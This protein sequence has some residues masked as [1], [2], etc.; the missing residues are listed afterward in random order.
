MQDYFSTEQGSERC[1]LR[2]TVLNYD[3]KSFP[4]TV[5]PSLFFPPREYRLPSLGSGKNA[6]LVEQTEEINSELLI[7]YVRQQFE[8]QWDKQDVYGFIVCRYNIT[9]CMCIT[10]TNWYILCYVRGNLKNW[11]CEKSKEDKMLVRTDKNPIKQWREKWPVAAES[12]KRWA[13]LT[14]SC[15]GLK[16]QMNVSFP[17]ANTRQIYLLVVFCE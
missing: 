12:E 15:Q 10:K 7:N 4:L 8:G 9:I 16:V 14:F 2:V 11:I 6:G 3:K 17:A 13:L 5:R 1:F